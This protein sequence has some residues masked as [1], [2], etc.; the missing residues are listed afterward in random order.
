MD[1]NRFPDIVLDTMKNLNMVIILYLTM[2]TVHSLSGYIYENSAMDFLMRVKRTPMEP[3]KLPILSVGLYLCLLLL[4]SIRCQRKTGF[5]LKTIL[6]LGIVFAISYVLNF[7][8]TGMA[9]LI[10]ADTMGHFS[11]M[12]QRLILMASICAVYIL[13]DYDL[14][15]A[16]HPIISIESCWAYYSK[17]MRSLL[18]GIRNILNSLNMIVFIIYAVGLILTEVREKERVLGLNERLNTANQELQAANEKLEEYA[19]ETEKAAETR[20][21]NRLA[22]EI[23]DTLGHSLTGIITGID[24]CVMLVDVAPEATKEQLKAIAGVAR[25]GIKDVRRSVK[26][27]R[28]DALESLNLKSALVQMMEETKRSTGVEITWQIEPALKGFNK[29]EEDIIYRIVQ[30]SITNAIRHGRA[31][32]VEVGIHR[33]Y[34]MLKIHIEDN[35]VGCSKVQKGFGLHHMEERLDMLKG[36]LSYHG[37]HGFVIDARIPIRWG[38]EEEND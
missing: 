2:V 15:S 27:L 32:K 13:L 14:L 7:S 6:E 25:Q 10:I 12:K 18:L 34:N 37:D 9:F 38:T 23:H 1:K 33:D 3:W 17:E 35:G 29:D 30:E 8:Y 19:R 28:P 36:S 16:G 21:R 20:E 5:L 26:A 4:L 11:D 24:A 31:D 22:R